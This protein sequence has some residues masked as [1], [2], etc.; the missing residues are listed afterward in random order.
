[1]N[2]FEQLEKLQYLRQ[3]NAITEQ[4]FETEKKKILNDTSSEKTNRQSK[5]VKRKMKPWQIILITILIIVIRIYNSCFCYG[6]YRQ[7]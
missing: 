5:K 1:M 4:E 7:L 6:S 2:K 3:N